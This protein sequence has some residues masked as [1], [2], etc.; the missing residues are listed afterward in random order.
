MDTHERKVCCRVS[1]GLKVKGILEISASTVAVISR[2]IE[3][4]VKLQ[5]S[6]GRVV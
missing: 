6:L 3:L 5:V 4:R 2:K 1:V